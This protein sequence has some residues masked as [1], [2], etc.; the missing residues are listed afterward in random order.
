MALHASRPIGIFDSGIGGLT[1]AKA[2]H[3][4]FPNENIIYFGD[5]AH[6]PYG[7]KSVY[8]LQSY[9]VKIL[10]LLVRELGCKAVII[11]CNSASAAA[12][13]L[14]KEFTGKQ[15][16]VINVIDP[17]VNY[18]AENYPNKRVG[19]IGT[20]ATINSR[21]YEEKINGTNKGIDLRSLATPL[22]ASIIEEGYIDNKISKS[23]IEEYLSDKTLENIEA[24]ILGC[25]HY[26]LIRNQIDDF[27]QHKVDIIDAPELV[28]KSLESFLT[29][30]GLHNIENTE[31]TKKFYVSDFTKSFE[32]STEIFFQE[33]V[34]LQAY[35]L[36]E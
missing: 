15:A 35:K 17:V 30:F 4:N 29:E 28:A 31:R 32:A 25:T 19:I 2:I 8:A 5:T 3:D 7:E 24:L 26:P 9:T 10:D 34:N 36:W 14:A 1:I 11:A 13:E 33:K 22:L 18:V 21:A 12:Y 20:R 6:L 23:V 27:Y 16:K